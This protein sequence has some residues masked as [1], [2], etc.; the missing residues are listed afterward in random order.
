MPP[1]RDNH[2]KAPYPKNTTTCVMMAG[3]KPLSRDRKFV[4]TWSP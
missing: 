2:H 3:V 1:I 4:I